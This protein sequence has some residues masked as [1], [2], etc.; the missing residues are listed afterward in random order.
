MDTIAAVIV[1]DAPDGFRRDGPALGSVPVAGLSGTERAALTA[2]RA[3]IDRVHF[4]GQEI[5][6]QAM[7]DRLE[8]RGLIVTATERR[9]SP[10]LDAPTADRLVVLPAETVVDPAALV[11]LIARSTR[12]TVGAV[13]MIDR[14][15]EAPNRLVKLSGD[16]V[17]SLLA[18]G[19]VASTDI[20]ILSPEAVFMARDT[21]S[22]RQAYRRLAR[23]GILHAFDP[24]PCFCERLK[25]PA[26]AARIERAYL[27]TFG[28]FL[29]L[30]MALLPAAVGRTFLTR[31]VS[32][33]RPCREPAAA[34]GH[35]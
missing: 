3:G 17:V 35:P 23:Y 34:G 19:D 12:M 2:R 31:G 30:P 26:D 10:F 22:V 6:D 14:R 9:G 32:T 5:P 20:A 7:I 16:R 27:K 28:G 21:V 4:S 11:G 24:A 29:R 13:L 15:L 25:S 18:D 1:T 33:A 8:R